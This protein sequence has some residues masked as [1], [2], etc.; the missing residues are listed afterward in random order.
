[1]MSNPTLLILRF[2]APLQSWGLRAVWYE[3]DT[4]SEPTKSGVIGLI[5]CAFGY[6]RNDPR[7][8]TKLNDHLTIGVRVER[9]GV[10][11]RDYHTIKSEFLR[12]NGK[13]EQKNGIITNRYYLEDASFVVVLSGPEPLLHEIKDALEHPKWL[14]YLGRKACVPTRP[15]L[16]GMTTEHASLKD[17]LKHIPWIK[18]NDREK[19]PPKRLRCVI[20]SPSG[21][22]SQHDNVQAT[23]M[24]T[25]GV[26]WFE[27]FH[28]PVPN[29]GNT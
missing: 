6:E 18:R 20:D 10:M 27:E 29:G 8:K 19:E 11:S 22:L 3:K 9:R 24:R 25:Y 12:S 23:P 15:I 2:E 17:A 16:D 4:A 1:M 14:L 5:A 13:I 7:L 21:S 26:R 28:V